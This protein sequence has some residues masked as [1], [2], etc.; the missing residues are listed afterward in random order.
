MELIK[1][2]HLWQ[3]VENLD[4]VG[5]D[6]APNGFLPL[7]MGVQENGKTIKNSETLKPTPAFTEFPDLI[8][9]IVSN[10]IPTLARAA[11]FKLP[12]GCSVRSHI[13]DGTYYHGKDRF[14]LSIHGNYEYTVDDEMHVIKPGTL[15]WFD[16]KRLHKAKNIDNVNRLTFVFDVP[17]EFSPIRDTEGNIN[18]NYRH[19]F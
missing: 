15:F 14:H 3:M 16:N 1:N 17:Y 10:N 11:F 4:Y 18:V 8:E 12:V 2:Q 13:D 9:T 7:V 6:L 5:G 19:N